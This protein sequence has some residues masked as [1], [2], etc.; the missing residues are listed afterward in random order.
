VAEIHYQDIGDYLSA[1]QKLAIV[2]DSSIATVPWRTIGQT[3]R[4]TG[5]T[6]A[7]IGTTS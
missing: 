5:S 2:S 1:V 4:P 7:T 3:S 6:L